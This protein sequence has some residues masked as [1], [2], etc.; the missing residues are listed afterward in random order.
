MKALSALRGTLRGAR[1][2]SSKPGDSFDALITDKYAVLRPKYNVPKHPVILCHGFLGFDRLSLLHRPNLIAKTGEKVSD[3]AEGLINVNYWHG[4]R[5]ALV[6]QGAKVMIAKVPP[7]GTIKDRA[8]HLDAFLTS[9]CENLRRKDEADS[10]I[11]KK[12]DIHTHGVSGEN[13]TLKEHTT[14]ASKITEKEGRI[15]TA[16]SGDDSSEKGSSLGSSPVKINLVS[17]SMGGLDARYLISKLHGPNRPYKVVSLTTVSTPHHGSECADFVQELIRQES[18]LGGFCP[19][20]IYQLTTGY[21]NQFN[22]EVLDDPTVAYFSYGARMHP[23][24]YSVFRPSWRII[25]RRLEKAGKGKTVYSDND[26]MVSV[27]SSKW[28][29]YLGTLDEV[30]HLDLINWTNKLRSLVDRLIFKTDPKFNPIA[31]YLDI[32][33]KLEKQGF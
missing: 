23:R 4:I 7:F 3:I 16:T 17:H 2:L 29:Q 13:G 11:E 21:L 9:Q 25:K 19:P 1:S 30:D 28:G 24:W 31:L 5:E 15:I 18:F 12:G 8:T 6:E 14:N 32:A 10:S 22:K 33:D 26:G 27:S 20:S